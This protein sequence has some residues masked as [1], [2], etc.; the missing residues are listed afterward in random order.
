MQTI[1]ITQ[2]ENDLKRLSQ[3]RKARQSWQL[4]HKEAIDTC[5]EAVRHGLIIK[6]MPGFELVDLDIETGHNS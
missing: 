5:K 1:K 2:E 3:C 6:V 4:L